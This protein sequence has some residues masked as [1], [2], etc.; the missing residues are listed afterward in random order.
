M[1][2]D[3]LRFIQIQTLQACK[4]SRNK[5]SVLYSNIMGTNS[6]RKCLLNWKITLIWQKQGTWF[7]LLAPTPRNSTSYTYTTIMEPSAP[8]ISY[9]NMPKNLGAY[10]TQ[11]RVSGIWNSG[12]CQMS[13]Q[14][15][16]IV[17]W[18]LLQALQGSHAPMQIALELHGCL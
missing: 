16:A 14:D 18:R 2:P 8:Y 12:Q 1:N 9:N 7:G 4:I 15:M 10:Q 13:W 17:V 5:L 11:S 6:W 3:R